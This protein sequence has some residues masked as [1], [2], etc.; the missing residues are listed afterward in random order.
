MT[1]PGFQITSAEEYDDCVSSIASLVRVRYYF[2][3][4]IAPGEELPIRR[5]T[6]D[7]FPTLILS[8]VPILSVPG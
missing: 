6:K 1:F 3:S 8:V 4:A 7:L 5:V 2:S